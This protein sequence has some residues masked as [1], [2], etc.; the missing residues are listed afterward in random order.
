MFCT[1]DSMTRTGRRRLNARLVVLGDPTT[2]SGDPT[3]HNKLE[4]EELGDTPTAGRTAGNGAQLRY[5]VPLES[6]MRETSLVDP[7]V[8]N[9][10]QADVAEQQHI[11][12][13]PG[14]LR[15]QRIRPT[16]CVTVHGGRYF[17]KLADLIS[18][19]TSCAPRM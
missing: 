16:F 15:R 4:L 1:G 10:R 3:G 11:S 8:M 13:V 17:S 5:V 14:V 9:Q 6:N 19:G 12:R 2:T 18:H 7:V